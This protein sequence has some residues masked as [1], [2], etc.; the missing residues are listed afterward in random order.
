MGYSKVYL[1]VTKPEYGFELTVYS[2][3]PKESG[4]GGSS[5]VY[6]AT[7]GCFNELELI[8]GI[9]MT[10]PKYFQAE[11]LHMKVAGG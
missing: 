1:G 6:A 8:N 3:F 2:D 5:V 4:L 9:H 10:L 11:R 7:I